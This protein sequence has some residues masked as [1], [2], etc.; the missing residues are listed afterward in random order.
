[1]I[2][3]FCSFIKCLDGSLHGEWER[4]ISSSPEVKQAKLNLD[5]ELEERVRKI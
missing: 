4:K 2:S 1:V 3:D 5:L